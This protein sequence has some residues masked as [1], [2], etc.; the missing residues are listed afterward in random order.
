MVKQS[1]F[2]MV[3]AHYYCLEC[4]KSFNGKRD[5]NKQGSVKCPKCKTPNNTVKYSH[6][7]VKIAI[8]KFK[9]AV[10]KEKIETVK[11]D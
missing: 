2:T 1:A 6:P 4:N 5:I 9:E 8:A 10:E 11:S 7:Y 3:E